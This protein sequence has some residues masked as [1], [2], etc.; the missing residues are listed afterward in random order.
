MLLQHRRISRTDCALSRNANGAAE[1]R[2]RRGQNIGSG[3][4]LSWT[5]T[6]VYTFQEDAVLSFGNEEN[7][8]KKKTFL[9]SERIKRGALENALEVC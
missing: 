1:L 4:D 6:P 5:M 8:L 9:S 2:R 7:S 3:E